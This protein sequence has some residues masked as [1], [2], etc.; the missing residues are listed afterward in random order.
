MP[1][2]SHSYTFI[3]NFGY[4][5]MQQLFSEVPKSDTFNKEGDLILDACVMLIIIE[6]FKMAPLI[7]IFE[8]S[9]IKA[10]ILRINGIT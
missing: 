5:M 7:S 8:W 10:Q 3:C 9:L 1:S 4:F 2:G 6:S